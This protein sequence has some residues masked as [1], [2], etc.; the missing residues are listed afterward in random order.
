LL[1]YIVA[2][3]TIMGGLYGAYTRIIRPHLLKT[4]MQ[5][6][7]QLI[8]DWFDEIDCNLEAGINLASI[9]NKENKIL[10]YIKNRLSSYWIRPSKR[11]IRKWNQNMGFK[12][13][14]WDSQ[15]MFQK[16]SR[17]PAVGIALDSFFNLL[18]GNFL[19]FHADYSAKNKQESNFADIEM[20][21]KFLRFYLK[22]KGYAE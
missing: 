22:E 8:T 18:V 14:Y 3:F 10:Y 2:L 4:K 7:N 20:P 15:E 6:F 16:F 17:I 5:K 9:N 1:G 11:I 12:R 19:E 13:E 21:V